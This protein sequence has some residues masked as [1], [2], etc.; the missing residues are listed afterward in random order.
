MRILSKSIYVHLTPLYYFLEELTKQ[1]TFVA[2]FL[3]VVP[4]SLA[5]LFHL[6]LSDTSTGW[7]SRSLQR[8]LSVNMQTDNGSETR[9]QVKQNNRV[10]SSPAFQIS[11]FISVLHYFPYQ[12]EFLFFFFW[13]Q[14]Y[15]QLILQ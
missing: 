10:R 1:S 13:G 2:M 6:P 9:N 3:Q 8:T 15:M 11:N 14:V 5:V 7:A 4:S 12:R